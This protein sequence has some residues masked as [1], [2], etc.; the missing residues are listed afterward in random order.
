MRISVLESITEDE[1]PAL[2]EMLN[3]GLQ[4]NNILI[5]GRIKLDV[6]ENEIMAMIQLAVDSFN[7]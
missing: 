1:I 6:R 4:N 3:K 5:K 7:D 2:E